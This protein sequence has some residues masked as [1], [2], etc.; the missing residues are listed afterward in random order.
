MARWIVKASSYH[1]A[2][3]MHT[4]TQRGYMTLWLT[5]KE[6]RDLAQQ[7]LDAVKE[8]ARDEATTLVEEGT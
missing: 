4:D 3:N 5:F 1:D 2:I 7:L 6:A 8:E